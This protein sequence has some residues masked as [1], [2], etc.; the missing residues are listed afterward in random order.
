[1]TTA[2]RRG[3]TLAWYYPQTLPSDPRYTPPPSWKAQHTQYCLANEF[4]TVQSINQSTKSV[5]DGF[6][7]WNKATLCIPPK[8]RDRNAALPF[9]N[10]SPCE[11]ENFLS[12]MCMILLAEESRRGGGVR[13]GQACNELR[14]VL[15]HLRENGPNVRF[16]CLDLRWSKLDGLETTKRK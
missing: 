15:S 9:T 16:V 10:S 7:L 4:M 11:M 5:H 12:P 2:K 6:P 14:W 13:L 8:E 3:H 1:M